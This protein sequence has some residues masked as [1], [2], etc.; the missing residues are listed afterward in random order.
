MVSAID[1]PGGG[2]SDLTGAQFTAESVKHESFD[3]FCSG[4]VWGVFCS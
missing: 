2:A 3:L 1:L 4:H